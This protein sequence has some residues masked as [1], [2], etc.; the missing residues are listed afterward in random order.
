MSSL[1]YLLAAALTTAVST[2]AIAQESR[3]SGRIINAETKRPAAG[4]TVTVTDRQGEVIA[5]TLADEQG[6][7]SVSTSSSGLVTVTVESGGY[8]S[9]R[10]NN[11]DL[12][13]DKGTI[14]DFALRPLD[15]IEEINVVGSPV[16]TSRQ[17]SI[18]SRTLSRE[19]I[20]RAPGTAG[21]I[22]RGL[23]AL[24][25]VNATGAYSS[26]SVRGRGPKDNII[27]VDDIPFG[28]TTHFDNSIGE[29]DEVAN[30][31][32][33]SIFGQNV[34]GQAEFIPG[35]WGAA[36]GG[37][38][39]SLLKLK[40]AEGNRDTPFVSGKVDLA[41]A[42][43]LYDGPSGIDDN[44]SMLLSVRHYD[45]GRLLDLIGAKD[46]GRPVMTDVLLKTVTRI[47]ED[48]KLK[49]IGIFAPEK[50]TRDT[51]HVVEA[52]APLDYMLFE[53]KQDAGALGVTL[54]QL[55]G[56]TG[57]WR[58]TVYYR[59]GKENTYQGEAFPELSDSP[60][61]PDAIPVEE[62]IISSRE[63]EKEFGWRSDY[64]Q[65]N[66][67]GRFQAG[68]RLTHISTDYRQSLSRD[69]VQ[70]VF[71]TDDFRPSEDQ[72]YILLTPELYDSA[73][74]KSGIRGA[75][76][77][78]QSFDYGSVTVTPGVR[79]EYDD[80][81]SSTTVSP[82]LQVD[83]QVNERARV[84]MTGGLYYQAPSMLEIAADPANV[85][86]DHERTLQFSAGLDY[87]L[88]DNY[89]MQ[90]EAY[91]QDMD[92]LIPD[93]DRV[94]GRLFNSGKG[95]AA[96]FDWVVRKDFSNR[97]SASARYSY[98]KTRIDDGD[99]NGYHP[100]KFN[101]PHL[102]NIT[103]NYE[104]NE[105]W[106]FGLQNQIASGRASEAY[107]IHEDVIPESGLLRYSREITDSYFGRNAYFSTLNFRAD[108]QT[109]I[110]GVRVRAFL[111]IVNALNRSNID[112]VDFSEIDG[113]I[114]SEGMGI[115]PQFGLAFEF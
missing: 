112:D 40:L 67:F 49:V 35:G 82:R 2:V 56:D 66:Q 30:G 23:N 62:R 36:Y 38:N 12:F 59:F 97:W 68:L 69:Y 37:L 9:A 22:F 27:L 52:E 47:D 11:V 99:G 76:Y 94:S 100:S 96:G 77:V 50:N 33:Y 61:D 84:N 103:L 72:K 105:N 104:L 83:W 46:V 115:I 92:K 64:S 113:L 6:N 63:D 106:S 90:I 25:G 86:L 85:D 51:S 41:G 10:E 57:E 5:S 111:D 65:D 45:F 4:A 8:Q 44:T 91:Y 13:A 107:I 14:V 73:F 29:E 17:G 98:N 34:V 70:Y 3:I 21:D 24:P 102:G 18:T 95:W 80:L 19:E 26:F 1:N 39:G 58:N 42:E 81:L 60:K 101:R 87:Y 79:L 55:V 48:T 74:K 32:R 28:R 31:G 53:S 88:G 109:Q 93:G 43:L 20:R 7:F 54:E 15:D 114:D 71:D 78:D 75:A 16:A 110:G 108:Y 89:S